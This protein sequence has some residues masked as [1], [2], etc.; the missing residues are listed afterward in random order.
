MK[1]II[2][3]F[4]LTDDLGIKSIAYDYNDTE[5]PS[6][7]ESLGKIAMAIIKSISLNKDSL[8]VQD[9]LNELNIEVK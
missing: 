4:E 2:L 7:S 9:L 1:M 6:N 3:T 5:L 8:I